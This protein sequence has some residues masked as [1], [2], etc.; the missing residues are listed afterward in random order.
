MDLAPIDE[1]DQNGTFHKEIDEC[2]A[3]V[4]QQTKEVKIHE[5]IASRHN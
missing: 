5:W 3:K 2:H 4:G 1:Q